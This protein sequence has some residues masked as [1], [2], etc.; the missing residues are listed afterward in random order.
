MKK[1]SLPLFFSGVLT[2]LFLSIGVQAAPAP[3]QVLMHVQKAAGDGKLFSHGSGVYLGGGLVLTAAHVIAVDPG[4]PEVKVMGR[5]G[6]VLDAK[7]VFDGT[8][9]EPDLDVALIKIDPAGLPPARRDQEPVN[10]CPS[11]PGLNKQVL[12]A[13]QEKVTPATTLGQPMERHNNSVNQ[14]QGW[15]NLL[16]TGFHHGASGG[17]VFDPSSD[18]LEGIV[19]LELTSPDGRIDLT[20]F[21]PATRIS[22]FLNQYFWQMGQ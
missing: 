2:A 3:D 16:T 8:R 19:S 20:S 7:V 18:C 15:T 6:V 17:G 1:S 10:V 9:I 12:V 21:I 4:H 14:T 11:N 5:E 22:P 13:A